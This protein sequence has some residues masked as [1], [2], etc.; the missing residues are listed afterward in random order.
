M[1]VDFRFPDVGEGI[2]EGTIV[3]WL[4]KEGDEVKADQ[5]LLEMETDKAVVELPSPQAGTVLK[6]HAEADAAIFVGDPLVT[7]GEPGERF[8]PFPRRPGRCRPPRLRSRP[9]LRRPARRSR[10]GDRWR[11]PA[12]VRWRA[13]WVLICPVSS[14]RVLADGSPTR[15]WNALRPAARRRHRLPPGPLE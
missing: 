8:R 3:K 2:H 13:S 4:V 5:A 14:D 1:A 12:P 15:T 9:S 10:L 6:L 11:R 7:I